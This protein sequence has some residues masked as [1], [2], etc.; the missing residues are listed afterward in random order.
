MKKENLKTIPIIV[1]AVVC[2]ISLSAVSTKLG[3]VSAERKYEA[4]I[5]SIHKA[6]KAAIEAFE[7]VL[8]NIDL[9]ADTNMRLGR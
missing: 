7:K 9:E 8:Y 3:Y 2:I 5:D 4:K 6:N 1:A